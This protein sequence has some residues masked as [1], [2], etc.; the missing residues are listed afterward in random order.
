MKP[1]Q[2][3]AMGL[4]II[5]LVAKFGGYDAYAD[6][7]GWLLVLI[8]ARALPVATPSRSAVLALGCL[9]AAV[10]VPLW[11]PPVA[12]WLADAD[13]ALEWAAYLP[14]F[15]FVALLCHALAGAAAAAGE[16]G[17]AAWLRVV[18]T[19]ALVV[20]AAPIVV[21]GAGL[22][23][24][25]DVAVVSGWLLHALTIWLLFSYSG[26]AWAGAPV[27]DGADRSGA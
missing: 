12:D 10:S 22:T 3:V 16:P 23:G 18:V 8:G 20:M 11:L 19:L 21:F 26:R 1:L 24:V 6:P 27:T 17:A 4:V 2:S 15:G 5:A 7:V 14:Q 25:A 9:A 13:A